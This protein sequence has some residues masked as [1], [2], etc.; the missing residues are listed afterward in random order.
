MPA[1]P[2]VRDCRPKPA[3]EPV[4]AR[5][6]IVSLG[7]M[8]YEMVTG[9]AAFARETAADTMAA[10]LNSDPAELGNGVVPA[11]VARVITRCLEKTR[12]ARYQSARDLA[13]GLEMLTGTNVPT[14]SKPLMLAL[15]IVT[16]RLGGLKSKALLMGFTVYSPAGR[17]TNS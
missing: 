12:E 17:L 11:A 1:A 8:F 6:D 4:D 13:F 5:S 7:A 15:L 16:V 14:K 9:H 2:V 3:P 10:I